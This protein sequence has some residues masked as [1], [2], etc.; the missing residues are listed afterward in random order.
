MV[1]VGKPRRGQQPK[2]QSLRRP[3]HTAVATAVVTLVLVV[4][5]LFV[6]MAF[7]ETSQ[8]LEAGS[9]TEVGLGRAVSLLGSI[10]ILAVFALRLVGPSPYVRRSRLVPAPVARELDRIRQVSLFGVGPLL[11]WTA[12]N[13]AAEINHLRTPPPMEAVH[14]LLRLTAEEVQGSSEYSEGFVSGAGTSVTEGTPEG[15]A[16]RTA[17][18]Q[19]NHEVRRGDTYWS[20]AETAYQDGTRWRE[21]RDLNKGRIVEPGFQLGD[22][23]DLRSGWRIHVPKA[24]EEQ[25]TEGQQ[26]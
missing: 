8:A 25:Q 6:A 10:A 14:H 20:L 3:W 23:I 11:G 5:I 24:V 22:E 1:R 21:I 7:V 18:P 17:L 9:V 13:P 15:R 4:L 26:Q 12:S 2:V 19:A 16:A